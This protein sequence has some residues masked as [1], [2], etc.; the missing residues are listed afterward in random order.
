MSGP[1]GPY[2]QKGKPED[3]KERPKRVSV[4]KKLDPLYVEIDVAVQ[5]LG[6]PRLLGKHPETEK[7]VRAGIGRYGPYVM[8]NQIY[9]SLKVEDD[10]LAV[11]LPRA[12]EL[13][14]DKKVRR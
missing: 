11:E 7:A 8:H 5:L 9:A 3:P 2:V 4:P 13:L 14:A 10:L 1:F 12:L 6:L